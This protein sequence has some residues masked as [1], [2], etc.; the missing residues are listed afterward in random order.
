MV[1][2]RKLRTNLALSAVSNVALALSQFLLIWLIASEGSVESVGQFV[3]VQT[4]LAPI[5]MFSQM[6]LRPV[7]AASAR[8]PQHLIQAIRTRCVT[9]TAAS[10]CILIPVAFLI[11]DVNLRGLFIALT[12][13]KFIESI[14]DI[15]YGAFQNQ[16]HFHWTSRAALLKCCIGIPLLSIT[17]SLTGSIVL[18]ASS[19]AISRA[20][21]LFLHDLPLFR[22]QLTL[23]SD[24]SLEEILDQNLI[25]WQ[26]LLP[27][28]ITALLLSL[29]SGIPRY[30]LSLWHGNEVVGQFS[31]IATVLLAATT[32]SAS[33]SQTFASQLGHAFLTHD[34]FTFK[35]IRI[36]IAKVQFGLVVF[37]VLCVLLA[38]KTFLHITFGNSAISLY[39]YLV[40]LMI[41]SATPIASGMT[42]TTL[43]AIKQY[44][45]ILPL[46]LL[47]V[48]T[49]LGINLLLVPRSGMTAAILGIALGGLPM[50]LIGQFIIWKETCPP[51][52]SLQI[53]H[54]SPREV[55]CVV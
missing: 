44:R 49:T 29:N 22:K 9:S 45:W 16:D 2:M 27:L 50:V 31:I 28:G 33:I 5:F 13:M 55:P 32:L 42:Y 24:A 1:V 25:R 6:E 7:V 37:A 46:N 41:A 43:L 35:T 39:P 26:A 48:S 14:S 8:S 11:S 23:P 47:V 34:Q 10:L 12:A 53:A 21:V 18:A 52:N 54:S 3:L 38:G 20:L 19:L 36:R 30:A 17:L 15:I 40:F 4:I 51:G